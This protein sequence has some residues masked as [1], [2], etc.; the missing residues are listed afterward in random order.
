MLD[1]KSD[2][3]FMRAEW[4]AMNTKR[5]LLFVVAVLV[6]EAQPARLGEIDLVGGDSKLT[7]DH[8]PDLHVNFRPVEGCFVSDFNVID[9]GVFEDAT[10]HF[11]GLLPKLRFINKLL[12]E[13]G[14]I[15]G[16]ELH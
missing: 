13:P 7:S 8:A 10:S 2:K 9:P 6:N 16:R 12:T 14:R 15:V 11:L 1:Q 5:R 4:G 3:T